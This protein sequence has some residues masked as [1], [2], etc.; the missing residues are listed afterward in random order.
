VA[1]AAQVCECPEKPPVRALCE[2]A[3]YSMGSPCQQCLLFKEKGYFHE[4]EQIRQ[5]HKV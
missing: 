5:I 4:K 2:G 1:R 3:G